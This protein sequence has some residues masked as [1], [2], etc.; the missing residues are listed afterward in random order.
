MEETEKNGEEWEET[1][2]DREEEIQ[3][4]EEDGNWEAREVEILMLYLQF[5]KFLIL[6]RTPNI[7][8]NFVIMPSKHYTN[9]NFFIY[10][11][12]L[13]HKIENTILHSS[14]INCM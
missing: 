8:I 1:E 5:F 13:A 7:K 11:T 10:S 2:K 4:E 14:L 9:E 6:P 3:E 12:F